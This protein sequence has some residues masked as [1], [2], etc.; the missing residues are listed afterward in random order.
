MYVLIRAVVLFDD[1][2][3]GKDDHFSVW[4]SHLIEGQ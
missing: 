2:G 4:L 3:Q 1:K